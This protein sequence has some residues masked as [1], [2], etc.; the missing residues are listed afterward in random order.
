M[1]VLVVYATFTN[2]AWVSPDSGTKI[3]VYP[4]MRNFSNKFYM[5]RNSY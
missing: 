1:N 3:L 5:N 4:N 2:N